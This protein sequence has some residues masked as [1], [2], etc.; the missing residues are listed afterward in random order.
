M[1]SIVNPLEGLSNSLIEFD[2]VEN[3]NP[4]DGA[5]DRGNQFSENWYAGD[6]SGSTEGKVEM[7]KDTKEL[8]DL[9]NKTS[10]WIRITK[11]WSTRKRNILALT[12]GI[13]IFVGL[14]FVI[15]CGKNYALK[16]QSKGITQNNLR[17][18]I[19][20]LIYKIGNQ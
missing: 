18:M 9:P 10:L 16:T 5:S 3:A 8:L 2:A 12:I 6:E 14:I 13:T 15:G 17:D 7:D 1:G 11:L 20:I 4:F 19:R